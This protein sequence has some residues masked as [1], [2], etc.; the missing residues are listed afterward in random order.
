MSIL[1]KLKLSNDEVISIE[2]STINQTNDPE[3]FKH[4][5]K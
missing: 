4:L 5:L 2:Y 1:N 3:W